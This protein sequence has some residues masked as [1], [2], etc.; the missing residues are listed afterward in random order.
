MDF[1]TT[2][3]PWVGAILTLM[4][5]TYL[6]KQNDLFR[7][8]EYTFIATVTANAVVLGLKSLNSLVMTPLM[9]QQ[10]SVL[11][12]AVLGLLVYARF[13]RQYIWISRWPL[14]LLTGVGTGLLMRGLIDAQFVRLIR[15]TVNVS[16]TENLGSTINSLL[17]ATGTILALSYFLFTVQDKIPISRG[18]GRLGRIV[19]MIT[20]GAT[21]ASL[22]MT[23]F[24]LFISRMQEIV[25]LLMGQ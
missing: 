16:F 3:G 25:L 7:F 2:I 11:L 18:M 15:S 10:F 1:F 13:S 14:A 22:A 19:L 21:F 4:V 8:A 6:Y 24:S 12:P 23:R 17:L 20:F 5:Y 9:N